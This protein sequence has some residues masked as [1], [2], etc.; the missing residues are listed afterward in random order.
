MARCKTG[1]GRAGGLLCVSQAS[2]LSIVH[3]GLA[4]TCPEFSE[5]DSQDGVAMQ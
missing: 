5:M 3:L 1:F 4:L 2:V